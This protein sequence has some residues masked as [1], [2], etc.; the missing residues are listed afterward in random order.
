MLHFVQALQTKVEEDE[1]SDVEAVQQVEDV[2][3]LTDFSI[4]NLKK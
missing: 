2:P 4:E 1:D 3:D